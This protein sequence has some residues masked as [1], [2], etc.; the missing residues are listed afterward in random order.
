MRVGYNEYAIDSFQ[1][2]GG[3]QLNYI[4]NFLLSIAAGIVGY[5]VCK[6]LDRK[7]KDS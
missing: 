5:Y 4:L 7:H 1:Q 6:W 2:E 3:V